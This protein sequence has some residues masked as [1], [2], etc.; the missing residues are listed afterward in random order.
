MNNTNWKNVNDGGGQPQPGGYICK[1]IAVE[2]VEDREFLKIY[3]DICFGEHAGYFQDLYDRYGFYGLTHIR[4]YKEKAAGLFKK[5]L[6]TLEESNAEFVADEFDNDPQKLV[7]LELG[8]VLQ[9]RRYTKAN[10]LD[11]TQLRVPQI[12]SRKAILD[13]NFIV[14][15]EIDDRDLPASTPTAGFFDVPADAD[16]TEG[17]PFR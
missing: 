17:L 11:G 2:D 8:A 1:I 7:G 9:L 4:S 14:P 3:L 12:C 10:G 6:K 5:F 13:G 15:D 16:E